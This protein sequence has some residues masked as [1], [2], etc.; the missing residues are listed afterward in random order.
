MI[1]S[2]FSNSV[3][4]F[5][6]LAL[7]ALAAV[8]SLH[9]ED[10]DLF[11]QPPM[12]SADLPNVL[13][14]LDNTANW[15]T[16]FT[17]EKAALV[18]LFSGLDANK[19]RVGV[20][21]FTESG[22]G[23]S[24]ED[25]GYVRAA[26]RQM[27][28][29]NKALYG[30]MINGLDVGDDKSNGGK[31]GKTMYEAY[32]YFV[33]GAPNSGNNKNKTDYTGNTYGASLPSKAIWALSGN[34]LTGKSGTPY[35]S[36]VGSD[37]E[38]NYIIYISNG[39][40]QDN[41]NDTTWATDRL[42]TVGGTTATAAISLNPSGSQ[43]NVG[44]EWARFMFKSA[45][46]IRTYTIDVNPITT[47]QGPG[48]SELLKSMGN[49]KNSG[50]GY[51]VVDS[52]A[53]AGSA[54]SIGR[55]LQTIF[56]EIQA[57]NS[58]FASVSL[59]VSVNTQGTY[60]NQV[61]IGMFRPDA[62]AKPRWAGNLKHYKMGLNTSG[63]LRLEDATGASAI[64]AQTGFISECVR[65]Y[66]TSD[67]AD[68]YWTF[69]PM[70]DCLISGANISNSPDGSVVEKGA[71][72]YRLRASTTRTMYTCS[73]SSCGS[74]SP[75]STT[76]VSATALGAADSTEHGQLVR[77]LKGLDV[78]DENANTVTLSEMRP[79][80]HGDVVHSR[81]VAVNYGT[82]ASRQVVVF[83][84]G[85]DGILRA[86][87]GNRTEAIGSVAAGGEIW[88]FA[89]PEFFSSVKRL[90]EN[91]VLIKYQTITSAS[92]LPKNYGMDGP[93]SLY[94]TEAKTMLYATQR[95]GGRSIYA[96]DVTT[97][98][99]P[100]VSWRIG[101]PNLTNDVGC[102]TGASD[103]GQTWASPKVVTAS[104]YTAGPL[105]IV[106]GGYDNC[107]DGDPNTCAAGSKGKGVYLI[108]AYSG[109]IQR[110]L[111]TDRGVVADV[112]VLNDSAGNAV[113]AYAADLGGNIYRLSFGAG[114]VGTWGWTKIAS[115]GCATAATCT[116]NRKFM[117]APDVVV[118]GS[119]HYLMIGSGDREKPLRDYVSN[120]T[121][122]NRMFMIK[123]KPSDASWLSAEY[124]NCGGNVICTSS[125]LA[126]PD[127]TTPSQT[128]ID[129]KKGWYLGLATQEQVVTSSIST[130]GVTTFSTHI[131]AQPAAASC[132][133]NLGV[134]NVY[135]INYMNASPGNGNSRFENVTGGG[136]S[137]SPVAGKVTLD[138]GQTVVFIIGA[139]G[140]SSI[141]AKLV[142][143][144]S[145]TASQP[146]S[147]VYW[148]RQR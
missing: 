143:P 117:F 103:I 99:S 87:N 72:A 16:P 24:N 115:L 77:W 136:L 139:S 113:Y 90:R 73:N 22:G 138:N 6:A 112:T 59:P 53:A 36:P 109:V 129:A 35:S 145:S 14:I 32:Q 38:K 88:S 123:D 94:R 40:V 64:N 42:Q 8:T 82:D 102:T 58:V 28:T 93:M 101:C 17:A 4:K 96:F 125:L 44:D 122:A 45:K 141:Q 78:D 34:A 140:Q 66:W 18:D 119:I 11:V 62:D 104:G 132:T 39:A 5:G 92:A 76:T 105:A 83:Y 86:V 25:G 79:S 21:M 97:P 50:G 9:A 70:G 2:W 10:I 61:Y 52:T 144:L 114:L 107:E 56:S 124:V 100:S 91:T 71:Q 13:I 146:K 128:A 63:D 67:T 47:G 41:S 27:T 106:G 131:P 69:R 65:S 142:K 3:I 111:D 120:I 23:N 51:Y 110:K 89:T 137:P 31:L 130:F 7:S 147:R 75:V 133:S 57:V 49:E 118:E 60:L 81:P 116:A 12:A 95:R 37:C 19:F 98:A 84:G 30:A 46:K 20:M 43:D 134:A 15:N 54:S 33:G 55:A 26:V 85:N 68:T 135:N 80:A 1:R 126:I 108:D 74:L 48:W 29:A 121:V 127:G 148:F